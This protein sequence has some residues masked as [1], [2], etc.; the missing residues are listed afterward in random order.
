MGVDVAEATMRIER[1]QRLMARE[2]IDALIIASP[3]NTLY[4]SGAFIVT[5]ELIP[6]R[7]ALVLVPRDGD[8]VFIVS[9]VEEGFARQFSCLPR[10]LVYTFVEFGDPAAPDAP[11]PMAVEL[12]QEW[13]LERAT[14]AIEGAF[15]PVELHRILRERLPDARVAH[16]DDLLAEARWVK[17]PGEIALLGAAARATKAAVL[18]A[19]S[20]SSAGWSEKQIADRIA[21]NLLAGGADMVTYVL[22]GSGPHSCMAHWPPTTAPVHA[23]QTVRVDVAGRFS[24]YYADFARTA[25]AGPPSGRQARFYRAVVRAHRRVIDAMRPGLPVAEL[26]SLAGRWIEKEGLPFRSLHIG[27]SIGVHLHE[28]PMITPW[29]R[30]ALEEHMVLN[31]EISY[32]DGE[33]AGYQVEDLVWVTASGHEVLTSPLPDGELPMLGSAGRAQ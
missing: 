2:G 12:L 20:A 28:R 9:R 15:M 14:V 1:L 21:G 8:P 26:F 16:G 29:A 22:L 7:L 3:E 30:E 10:V 11:I 19:F 4:L 18:E 33:T 32:R 13:R 31:V 17:T 6:R 5:H 24:G 23:G 25:V 27:H